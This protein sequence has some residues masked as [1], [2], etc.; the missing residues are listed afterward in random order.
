MD[1]DAITSPGSD[2]DPIV[3]LDVGGKVFYFHLSILL[4]SGSTYFSNRFNGNFDSGVAYTDDRGRNVF[5]IDRSPTRFEYVRDYIVTL[6]LYIPPNDITL[7]RC[8][9]EE[10]EYFGIE[11]LTECLRVSHVETPNLDNQGVLY[12]LGTRRRTAN[13]ENPFAIGECHVGGWIDDIKNSTEAFFD[14]AAT[15][16]TRQNFVGYRTPVRIDGEAYRIKHVSFLMTC[17][18]GGARLPVVVDLKFIH[19]RPTHYSLRASKCRG[20]EGDWNFEASEDGETW[21][22]LHAARDDNNLLLDH[23]PGRRTSA[24][25]FLQKAMQEYIYTEEEALDAVISFMELHHRHTWALDP[26]PDKF[27]RFFRIIGA[28]EIGEGT[29]LHGDGLELYGEVYEE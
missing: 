7:R 11:G 20:M 4:N 9:R 24:E 2:N 1:I 8:L 27:Y 10:A 16:N 25:S 22:I 28:D 14:F 21:D 18:H 13:Y 19:L 3:G 6:N 26:V 12:W 17:E 5:F 23:A 15:H 29:C